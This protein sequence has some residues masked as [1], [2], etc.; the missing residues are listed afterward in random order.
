VQPGDYVEL[1]ARTRAPITVQTTV[2]GFY[3]VVQV[4]STALRLELTPYQRT[5]EGTFSLRTGVTLPTEIN[6]Q[7][8]W[9]VLR[10]RT[11]VVYLRFNSA[12]FS[13]VLPDDYVKTTS[14]SGTSR[15]FRA[16]SVPTPTLLLLQPTL[17]NAGPGGTAPYTAGALLGTLPATTCTFTVSRAPTDELA[18]FTVTNS[19]GTF[20]QARIGDYVMLTAQA[21]TASAAV[22]AGK[23]YKIVNIAGPT[24]HLDNEKTE[25]VGQAFVSVGKAYAT[26]TDLAGCQVYR[27][28]VTH[29]FSEAP[30]VGSAPA[31]PILY[32]VQSVTSTTATL[33]Q[34]RYRDYDAANYELGNLSEIT[35]SVDFALLDDHF[36][37]DVIRANFTENLFLHGPG[38]NL[39]AGTAFTPTTYAKLS[40]TAPSPYYAAHRVTAQPVP[41]FLLLASTRLDGRALEGAGSMFAPYTASALPPVLTAPGSRTANFSVVQVQLNEYDRLVLHAGSGEFATGVQAADRILID[42]LPPSA[43]DA[44]G[45]GARVAIQTAVTPRYFSVQSVSADRKVLVLNAAAPMALKPTVQNE[46]A[47][48]AID[49]EAVTGLNPVQLSSFSLAA[50]A[51]CMRP[52]A[53]TDFIRLEGLSSSAITLDMFAKL[54]LGVAPTSADYVFEVL[55]FSPTQASVE[56]RTAQ[57]T[58]VN[59]VYT[60]SPTA[61]YDFPEQR[62]T[63]IERVRFQTRTDALANVTAQLAAFTAKLPAALRTAG[64]QVIARL[65]SPTVSQGDIVSTIHT[66]AAQVADVIPEL[67][68]T[69]RGGFVGES[70][71]TTPRAYATMTQTS[72]ATANVAQQPWFQD[73]MG[74]VATASYSKTFLN[75]TG[76]VAQQE[77]GKSVTKIKNLYVDASLQ[78]LGY[79]AQLSN[80]VPVLS[81]GAKHRISALLFLAEKM[82]TSAKEA[83]IALGRTAVATQA[84]TAITGLFNAM[85][86]AIPADF[87]ADK[88]TFF[89]T[90]NGV[91]FASALP[92]YPAQLLTGLKSD[93][94]RARRKAVQDFVAIAPETS[95]AVLKR[96]YTRIRARQRSRAITLADL[97]NHYAQTTDPQS[98]RLLENAMAAVQARKAADQPA[99]DAKAAEGAARGIA[100]PAP[101]PAPELDQTAVENAT[102]E[103]VELVSANVTEAPTVRPYVPGTV[104]PPPPV[105]KAG[106]P[107]QSAPA[108]APSKDSSPMLPV[109]NL[110]G[111]DILDFRMISAAV[112]LAALNAAQFN[113]G[114][115]AHITLCDFDGRN[116]GVLRGS[117]AGHHLE[118]LEGLDSSHSGFRYNQFKLTGLQEA[119]TEK[120]QLVDT[121]SD[122]FMAFAFGPR[123]E[124]WSISGVLINDVVSDQLNKFRL[125]YEKFLRIT[126]LA[127]HKQK[128]VI[129]IPALRIKV[130]G[131][132]V[133]FVPQ[134]NPEV[135]TA[136]PFTLQILVTNWATLPLAQGGDTAQRAAK[137]S[138]LLA[139]LQRQAATTKADTKAPTS[140]PPQEVA[141]KKRKAAQTVVDWFKKTFPPIG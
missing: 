48:S 79:S 109:T 130:Y 34:A 123:P 86:P 72:V 43:A 138:K 26:L 128:M 70:L 59:N 50:N 18:V 30:A 1:I 39:P 99:E 38:A 46:S 93:D 14:T 73:I 105:P 108:P 2:S 112:P 31:Q 25:L 15:I 98:R 106:T 7:F 117:S 131:Y 5:A 33:R 96:S 133:A 103:T 53:R 104:P 119:H 140:K 52:A 122:S 124:M 21:G 97:Q 12:V 61:T 87:G 121:L 64:D 127:E 32:E 116:E 89:V 111:G 129:V 41:N 88:R 54:T 141:D 77:Q 66:V 78:V 49:L 56:L 16:A 42:A 55:G 4:F 68:V 120:F 17:Y 114:N 44:A 80:T 45:L 62:S 28:T 3:K 24:L 19:T 139:D 20:T 137:V 90:G 107:A 63:A 74:I 100:F 91:D 95:V 29:P 65:Y 75:G 37:V 82:K 92:V 83:L 27:S 76:Q 11:D 115:Y 85:Q 67:P 84:D 94:A 9:R 40:V 47:V 13:T 134:H 23:Y 132:A 81:P 58:V 102:N 136:T 110:F 71:E 57:V 113:A 51:A 22:F 135:Q 36:D 60:V 69:I 125:L 101:R 10:V 118:G 35:A 6:D 8:D 126:A